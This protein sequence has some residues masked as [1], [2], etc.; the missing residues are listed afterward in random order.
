MAIT[1]LNWNSTIYKSPDLKAFISLGADPEKPEQMIY[2]VNLTDDDHREYF[3][4]EFLSLETACSFI[5]ERWG[6]WEETDLGKSGGCGT[7]SAH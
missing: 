3:Q 1:P 4:Q 5:N 2:L 7:C 6:D